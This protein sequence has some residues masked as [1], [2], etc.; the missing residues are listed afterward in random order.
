MGDGGVVA[1]FKGHAGLQGYDGILHGGIV[2][3][4]LDAAMTHCLF[5]HGIKAVTDE[6]NVRFLRPVPFAAILTVS[7][8][9]KALKLPIFKL[10][11]ELTGDGRVMARAEA[12]F[13][14]M[15]GDGA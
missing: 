3:A 1:P 14:R 12:R 8:R 9:P 6:L 13:M 7:A 2:S 15:K 5:R 11:A 4:L 10:A